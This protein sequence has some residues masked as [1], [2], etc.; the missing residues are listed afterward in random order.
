VRTL[1]PRLVGQTIR[2]V[3]SSGLGLRQR[4]AVDEAALRR[5]CRGA[6]VAGVSRRGKLVLIDLERRQRRTGTLLVHLGMTGRLRLDSAA[7]PREKH[8]H[9]VWVLSGGRELR[10]VDARRFGWVAAA[11]AA[12]ELPDLARL[13]PDALDGLEPRAFAES[14]AKSSAPIKSFLLDQRRLAGLGN[15]YAA[16]ALFRAGLHPRTPARRVRPKSEVLRRAIRHTLALGIRNCGTSFRDFVDANGEPGTNLDALLVYGRQ[17]EA[18][19][20]CGG[21]IRRSVDAGRSTFFCP[22]CQRR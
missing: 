19:R 7:A 11:A 1:R 10:F 20:R 6:R 15:I 18:C 9:V 12:A 2:T 4:R 5:H 21:R 14:L 17:G 8:I 3:W 13:G 22:R 16:E